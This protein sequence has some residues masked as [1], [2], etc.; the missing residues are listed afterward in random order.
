MEFDHRPLLQYVMASKTISERS[1]AKFF[2]AMTSNNNNDDD[3]DYDLLEHTIGQ[4]NV[5]MLPM[6][7]EIK[8]HKDRNN[9]EDRNIYYSFVNLVEDQPSKLNTEYSAEDIKVIT[10]VIQQCTDDNNNNISSSEALNLYHEITG[11]S[12]V[13]GQQLFKSMVS[14][15]WLVDDRGKYSLGLR[16][17]AELD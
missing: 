8:R 17:V 15:G 3:Y 10:T 9:L 11:K 13:A 2:K 4:I 6:N 12:M 7:Y 16:L 14:N 1:L 5:M